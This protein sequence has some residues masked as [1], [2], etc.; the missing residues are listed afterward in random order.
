MSSALFNSPNYRDFSSPLARDLAWLLDPQFDLAV[1]TSP[2]SAL[3]PEPSAVTAHWLHQL[4]AAAQVADAP[5]P[6]RRLGHYF[7]ALVEFYLLNCP[8]SGVTDLQRNVALRKNAADGKGVNTIGELDFLFHQQGRKKHLEVAVKFYLGIELNQERLWLGPNSKDRLDKKWWRMVSHQ[9]PL[10]QQFQVREADSQYWL[11]GILFEPW[12][13]HPKYIKAGR[14]HS[15]HWLTAENAAFYFAEHPGDWLWLPKAHWLGATASAAR[16]LP[17]E[18]VPQALQQH[19]ARDQFGVMLAHRC[20]V[21]RRCFVV[22]N[23]W[24]AAEASSRAPRVQL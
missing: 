6:H 8:D 21:E 17:S 12:H 23:N 4:D 7:E 24:P 5:R 3:D 20:A 1:P 14:D 18:A 22:D 11:K 15:F 2:Y 13:S 19:F 10:A 16:T 9:L